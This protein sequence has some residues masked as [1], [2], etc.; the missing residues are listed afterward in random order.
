VVAFLVP[1]IVFIGALAGFGRLLKDVVAAS[2]QVPL[3]VALAL[4]TTI[5]VMLVVRAWTRP[6]RK[7]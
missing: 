5:G 2:Y 1:I 6:H 7:Q 4:T 3:A